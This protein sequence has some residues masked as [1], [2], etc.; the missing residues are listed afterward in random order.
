MFW[1]LETADIILCADVQAT[2]LHLLVDHVIFW[3]HSMFLSTMHADVTGL[4]P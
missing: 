4:T 1:G 3:T 2:V